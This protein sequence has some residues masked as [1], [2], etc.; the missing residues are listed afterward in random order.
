[1]PSSS[2]VSL[3]TTTGCHR[4]LALSGRGTSRRAARSGSMRRVSASSLTST[5]LRRD[6]GVDLFEAPEAPIEFCPSGPPIA[7]LRGE[8]RRLVLGV[9][10]Y[11]RPNV[12]QQAA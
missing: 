9:V 7:D 4:L 3:G 6:V 8:L 5:P 1:M 10:S 2:L 11:E 12:D